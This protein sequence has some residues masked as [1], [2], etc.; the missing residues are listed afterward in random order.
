MQSARRFRV[1][2]AAQSVCAGV[3]KKVAPCGLTREGTNVQTVGVVN[4]KG[5]V[6]KST[7][8]TNLVATAHLAGRRALLIDLDRQGSALDW[9]AARGEA[10]R[11]QG[12]AVVR[13]DRPLTLPRFREIAAGCDFVVLDGPPQVGDITRSAAVVADWVI[14]PSQPSGFDL[15]AVSATLDA[16]DQADAIR[17]QLELPPVRRLFVINRAIPGTLLA[18]QAPEALAER[19]ELAEAML[20]QRVAYAEAAAAGES[21]MT[22]QPAGPAAEEIRRLYRALLTAST[23]ERAA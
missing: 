15:W 16:I 1:S 4:Q 20:C 13:Y 10:S 19:G 12:I 9:H 8:A 6:G 5:G 23:Q 17:A 11:L 14:I 22:T 2:T 7:I 21:V 3:R 18:R